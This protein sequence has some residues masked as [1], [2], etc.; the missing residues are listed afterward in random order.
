MAEETKYKIGFRLYAEVE[1][2]AEQLKT[3]AKGD[4]S[5]IEYLIEVGQVSLGGGDSY[6]PIQWLQ[7]NEELPAE[8]R[9]DVSR[10]AEFDDITVD[11]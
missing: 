5:Y 10:L 2:T 7:E 3:A 4:S 6:I 1:L 11:A 9:D 8:L